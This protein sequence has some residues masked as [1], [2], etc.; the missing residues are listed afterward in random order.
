[1]LHGGQA[2]LDLRWKTLPEL[3]R[4]IPAAQVRRVVTEGIAVFGT[5]G[6]SSLEM[7]GTPRKGSDAP[8]ARA[9]STRLN[10]VVV[11][12]EGRLWGSHSGDEVCRV[13]LCADCSK[14]S[15]G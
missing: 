5:G 14:E 6:A 3:L 9:A 4:D 1:V 11:D 13:G 2:R 7:R 10:R 12:G 15:G 8:T